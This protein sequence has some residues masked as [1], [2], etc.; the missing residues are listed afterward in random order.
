V[1]VVDGG[2]KGGESR[3]RRLDSMPVAAVAD[4]PI[5]WWWFSLWFGGEDLIERLTSREREREEEEEEEEEET[6]ATSSDTQPANVSLA[7]GAAGARTSFMGRHRLHPPSPPP[8]TVL[9]QLTKSVSF[10]FLFF[11]LR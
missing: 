11:F 3:R 4:S 9:A 8:A 5:W 7:V 2:S 1:V 6:P 10:Y